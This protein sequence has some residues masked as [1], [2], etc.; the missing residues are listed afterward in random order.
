[1]ENSNKSYGSHRKKQK[2]DRNNAIGAFSLRVFCDQQ[3]RSRRIPAYNGAFLDLQ[4]DWQ[5]VIEFNP[6]EL[7]PDPFKCLPDD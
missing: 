1:M 3:V 5:Q 2:I 7:G 6:W 4:A